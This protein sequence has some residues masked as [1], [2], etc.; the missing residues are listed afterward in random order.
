MPT[1]KISLE[2][3]RINAKLTQKE[4][5]EKLGVSEQTMVYWERGDRQPNVKMA[6]KLC[7]LY[8]RNLLEIEW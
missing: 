7:D 1:F 6:E 8:G 3:A 2:A 5:A 4:A